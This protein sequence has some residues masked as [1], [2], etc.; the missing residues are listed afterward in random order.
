M[1]GKSR[2]V[3]GLKKMELRKGERKIKD[4]SLARQDL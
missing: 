3:T 2:W 1:K 4:C